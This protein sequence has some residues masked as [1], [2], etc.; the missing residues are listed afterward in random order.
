MNFLFQVDEIISYEFFSQHNILNG[1]IW[2]MKQWNITFL[3][4]KPCLS[5]IVWLSWCQIKIYRYIHEDFNASQ[6]KF[7]DFVVESYL[8]QIHVIFQNFFNMY[9][10]CFKKWGEIKI[11]SDLLLNFILPHYCQ[12]SHIDKHV[13][14]CENLI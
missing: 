6:R 8:I 1:W 4:W 12:S 7:H 10:K 13:Y 5:I 11:L 3:Y 2:L 14:G 9:V